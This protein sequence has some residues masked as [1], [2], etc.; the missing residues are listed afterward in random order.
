M[1]TA[2]YWLDSAFFFF[3]IHERQRIWIL[4]CVNIDEKVWGEMVKKKLYNYQAFFF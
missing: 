4:V 3:W 1:C 2:H